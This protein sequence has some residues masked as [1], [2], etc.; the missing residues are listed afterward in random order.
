MN[1]KVVLAYS[2]GLDTTFCLV[3]LLE[4]GYEVYTA[5]VNTGSVDEPEQ[6]KIQQR[7]LQ[8]GAKNHFNINA[9][10]NF[11]DKII[12]YIIKFNALYE[13]DY[14]LMCTDRYIISEEVIKIASELNADSV[15][16]GCTNI[17]NDQ[18]RFDSALTYLNSSI[19]IIKPIK[20]LNITRQEELKYLKER[21]VQIEFKFSKYSIN[22]NILGCTVS[23]SEID[24]HLEPDLGA[25]QLSKMNN[26]IE[27][28][29]II[30]SFKNGEVVGFNNENMSKAGIL[31]LLNDIGS[32]YSIGQ[33]IYSGDCI[34]G[35]KGRILFEAPGILILMKAYRKLSQYILTKQQISFVKLSSE[36]W[37]DLVYSGLYFEPLCRNLEYFIDNTSENFSGLVK[38]KLIPNNFEIVEVKTEQSLFNNDIAIYAQKS[39]L[40]MAETDGFIKLYTL[41]QNISGLK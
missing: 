16:H 29:Y 10:N 8:L 26:S 24:K 20:E 32:H 35:I 25:Y 15:A 12:K 19:N 18:V 28:S 39:K 21:N 6:L 40:S 17:G 37:S 2:G 4:K 9:E 33:N 22:Q 36:K 14:P 23:G 1:K 27:P 30:L 38:I 34:I 31:K 13:D 41:Q 5:Y 3:Y 7:A 11:Y